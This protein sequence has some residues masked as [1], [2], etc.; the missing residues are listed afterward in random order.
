MSEEAAANGIT[1]VP[2]MPFTVSRTRVY[3]VDQDFMLHSIDERGAK[4]TLFRVA[5]AGRRRIAVAVASDDSRI[6]VGVIDYSKAAKDGTGTISN[7]IY[8]IALPAGN[9][10]VDLFQQTIKV[11]N[12]YQP[13]NNYLEWPIAWYGHH[14]IVDVSQ[15]AQ[16]GS[17]YSGY[18]GHETMAQEIHVADSS[19]GH[20]TASLCENGY[21]VQPVTPAGSWCVINGYPNGNVTA[22]IIRWDGT[23]HVLQRTT[24]G[25]VDQIGAFS[26]D[27]VR[28]AVNGFNKTPQCSTS[29]VIS[30]LGSNGRIATSGVAGLPLIWLDPTHLV[31]SPGT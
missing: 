17:D 12:L 24:N 28:T 1:G 10:R 29:D 21:V 18:R 31:Y 6:A 22:E 4:S 2:T 9:R 11:Q 27:G 20:R 3:Y 14:L 16:F 26:P 15:Q 5:T 25:C 13:Q 8:S 19:T 30:L 23:H 7:T